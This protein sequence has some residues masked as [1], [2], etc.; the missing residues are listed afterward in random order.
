MVVAT[1][2][3]VLALLLAWKRKAP[4]ITALLALIAGAG[5]T[6]GMIGTYTS[7][8]VTYTQGLTATATNQAVGVAV[9]AIL[10]ITLAF[11]VLHDMWPKHN[12]SRFTAVAAFFLP[13][14]AASIPGPFGDG[15]RALINGVVGVGGGLIG[16]ATNQ[17]PAGG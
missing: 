3:A 16:G 9:P 5:L 2:A 6:A 1:I 15:V 14:V 13:V 7:R 11:I 10:G 12:A 4:K 17:A 8:F